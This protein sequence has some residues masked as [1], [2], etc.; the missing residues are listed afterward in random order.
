MG[1][2]VAEAVQQEMSRGGAAPPSSGSG[3]MAAAAG[4]GAA[5]TIGGSAMQ[6]K[7]A[8]DAARI[9]AQS[10]DKALAFQRQ[11]EEQRKAVYDQK[12]VEYTNMRNTLAQRYGITL[13]SSGVGGTGGAY[14][15]VKAKEILAGP[16]AFTK[17]MSEWKAANPGATDADRLSAERA[18]RGQLTGQDLQNPNFV[19]TYTYDDIVKPVPGV[20]APGTTVGGLIRP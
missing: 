11:Q 7:A 1:D 20:P 6:G 13:P 14:Q 3:N 8:K 15:P 12:M 5:A 4:I 10:Y 2:W 16:D 19:G 9:Q 17:Y 18:F